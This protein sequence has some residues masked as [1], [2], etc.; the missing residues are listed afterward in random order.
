MFFI[1]SDDVNCFVC[2]KHPRITI[3]TTVMSAASPEKYS[4]VV[5][6]K[7]LRHDF[8]YLCQNV[9]LL[10]TH[11]L[12]SPLRPART[13]TESSATEQWES[14]TFFLHVCSASWHRHIDEHFTPTL[15]SNETAFNES[16]GCD[17]LCSLHF[18]PIT[19]DGLD[20]GKGSSV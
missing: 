19:V 3:Y 9:W 12:W 11:F 1:T 14:C 13:L 20:W 8:K 16:S 18:N 4:T 2:L 7:V 6:A 17:Y 15:W 10:L 5:R